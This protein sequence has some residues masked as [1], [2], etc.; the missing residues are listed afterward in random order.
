MAIFTFY[1]HDPAH[2]V[3]RFEIELLDGP[4]D[5]IA[6]GQRL[7]AARPHYTAVTITEGDAEVARLLRSAA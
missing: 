5:A 7:L 4:E 1:L 6:H 3:P 2:D